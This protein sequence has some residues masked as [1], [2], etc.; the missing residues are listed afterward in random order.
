[1]VLLAVFIRIVRMEIIRFRWRSA[2]SNTSISGTKVSRPQERWLQAHTSECSCLFHRREDAPFPATWPD[3]T[4]SYTGG[5]YHTRRCTPARLVQLAAC[6]W[7]FPE[8]ALTADNRKGS[9]GCQPWP[10]PV[11]MGSHGAAA[12]SPNRGSFPST[13]EP[14]VSRRNSNLHQM[15]FPQHFA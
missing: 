2:S 11:D 14:Y 1:M 13:S 10:C 4:A 15:C 9:A 5:A 6:S 7:P 12:A 8:C 3:C